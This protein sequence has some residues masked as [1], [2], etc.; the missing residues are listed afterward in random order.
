MVISLLL[1]I[2]LVV[3][4]IPSETVAQGGIDDIDRSAVIIERV[5]RYLSDNYVDE[6]DTDTLLEGALK[7]LLESL[8]DPFSIYLSAEAMRDLEDTTEGRFGGV[9]CLSANRHWM[10]G[11]R[12]PLSR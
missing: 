1:V 2:A 11:R 7:G 9:A 5:M 10:K 6:I 4:L 12:S 8:S 3:L